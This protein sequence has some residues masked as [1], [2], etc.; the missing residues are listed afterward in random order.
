[1]SQQPDDRWVTFGYEVEMF[2]CLL[3]HLRQSRQTLEPLPWEIGNAITE[4]ALLHARQ[5][6]DILLS[7][8][9]EPTDIKLKE[10]LPGFQPTRLDEFRR[11]YG[12]RNSGICRDLNKY[13]M[14]PSTLRK[15]MH[16]YTPIL[17]ELGQIIE[18]IVCEI[19]QQQ[20]STARVW[21]RAGKPR[22][23]VRISAQAITHVPELQV[24]K[25]E[26]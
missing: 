6:A 22:A 3:R 17:Q 19:E 8:T 10:L 18:E 11:V 15:E 23:T 20:G 1:M 9:T 25:S 12:D 24:F 26:E 16:D 7:R 4:S 14:H 2:R 5:L 13:A 21:M